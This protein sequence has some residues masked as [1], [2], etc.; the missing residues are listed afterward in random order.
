MKMKKGLIIIFCTLTIALFLNACSGAETEVYSEEKTKE[1]ENTDTTMAEAPKSNDADIVSDADAARA[2]I[3][4]QRMKRR[5]FE[6]EDQRQVKSTSKTFKCN[7]CNTK[8]HEDG[9]HDKCMLV[10]DVNGN[11]I[12]TGVELLLNIP[13]AFCSQACYDKFHEHKHDGHEVEY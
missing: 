10:K 8:F 2:E 5:E 4:E 6:E 11:R 13:P 9:I 3:L 7:Y 1:I 12:E